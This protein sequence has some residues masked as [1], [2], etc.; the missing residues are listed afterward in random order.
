M[1]TLLSKL[2]CR[3]MAALGVAAL[4][5]TLS[6]AGLASVAQAEVRLRI[7]G[8]H[9]P[10]HSNTILLEEIAEELEAADVGLTVQLFPANQLGSGEQ[11][12]GDVQRGVIDI[13]HTFV[14]SINDPRL[15]INSIPYLVENYEQ[16]RRVF[17]PGSAFYTEFSNLLAEQDI[18]L[19]GIVGEGFIGVGA[20]DR[21]ENA[22]TVGDKGLTIR[23]WSANVARQTAQDLGFSTTTIDWGDV[24]PALQQGVVD[25]VIGGTPEANYTAFRDAISYYVPYNS[26]VENTAYYMGQGTWDELEPAQRE[27]IEA[28]FSRAALASFDQ[29]EARD[30]EFT[31]LLG[32]AGIEVIEIS[33]DER[34]ALAAHVRETTWPTLEDSLG[35]DL[36]NALRADVE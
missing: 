11:V 31:A 27:V 32:E 21:P 28:A 16:M 1:S 22:T 7:A 15:E 33:D 25:G 10:D 30:A 5:G 35:P 26:F 13:A 19:L 20:S 17:T 24:F 34:A 9:A 12:F 2:R 23:V 6:L 36:L 8:S 18:R 14:Y 3:P 29:A 4:A